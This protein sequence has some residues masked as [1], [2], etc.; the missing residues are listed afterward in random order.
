M[1]R[2]SFKKLV[3][4]AQEEGELHTKSTENIFNIIIE[5]FPNLNRGPSKYKRYI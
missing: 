4:M 1:P 5:D 2:T 3:I